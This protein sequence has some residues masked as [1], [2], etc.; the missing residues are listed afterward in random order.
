MAKPL[1]FAIPKGRI[2]QIIRGRAFDMASVVTQM[3]V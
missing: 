3:G 2:L 1:V